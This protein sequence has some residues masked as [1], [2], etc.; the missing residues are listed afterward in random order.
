MPKDTPKTGPTSRAAALAR[1]GLV[2]ADSRGPFGLRDLI[3][4]SPSA[5]WGVLIWGLFIVVCTIFAVWARQQPL[6]AVNRVMNETA[7]VRVE[8]AIVDKERTESYRIL[9]RQ[10]APRIFTAAAAVAENLR[11]AIERLPKAL[12]STDRFEMVNPDIRHIFRLDEESFAAI[13]AEA[14][15]GEL[16]PSWQERTRRLVDLMARKP[17]VDA[18]TYQR[19]AGA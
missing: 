16:S 18:A 1:R 7:L 11:S 9:A 8:F 17:L 13:R 2:R 3:F 14:P 12:A 5:A 15:G 6:V 10:Q 4:G 19:M